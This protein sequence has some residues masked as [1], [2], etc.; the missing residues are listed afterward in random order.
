[1][2]TLFDEGGVVVACAEPALARLLEGFRWRELF[3]ARR[4]EVIA[5]MKF[6]VFG[7]AVLEHALAP[8]KGVTAKALDV[9][10]P[11]E[12]L[13]LPAPALV[14]ALDERAAAHFARPEALAST[15]TL[16][17][18][19]MLGIPGWSRDNQDAA[20]YDDER[21]FRPGRTRGRAPPA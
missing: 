20:F 9:H 15:R 8:Y 5:A 6:F 10:V 18:L 21:V 11:R 17:P 19:P 2:A 1:V 16:H 12:S 3:W 13:A 4:Q 7:H 14:A